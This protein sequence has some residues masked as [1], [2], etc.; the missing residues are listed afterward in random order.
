M[1]LWTKANRPGQWNKLME[2]GEQVYVNCIA[3]HGDQGQGVPPTFPPLTDSPITTGPIEEH[4][5]IV[6]KGKLN[7]TMVAFEQ[8]LSDADIAAVITYER[9]ALG[10]SVGDLV[11]PSEIKARR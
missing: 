1:Q 3:C 7:T 9:N 8:Q 11:Q 4:I 2:R 6:M 10:N 5:N